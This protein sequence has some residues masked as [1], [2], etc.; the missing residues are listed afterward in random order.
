MRAQIEQRDGVIHVSGELNAATVPRL[1]SDAAALFAQS[2]ADLTIDLAGVSRADS[3][4][5]ALLLDWMRSARQ[6]QQQLHFQRL[7]AQLLDM[8]RVSGIEELLP[9]K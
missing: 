4:G 3:S 1:L 7:P 8:A 6:Q 5:L 2:G 9:L